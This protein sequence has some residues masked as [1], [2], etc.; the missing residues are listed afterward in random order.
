MSSSLT[1]D[2]SSLCARFMSSLI[3]WQVSS[4]TYV[5]VEKSDEVGAYE[6][7]RVE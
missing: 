1:H 3:I 5:R 6:S 2:W 7:A 4:I